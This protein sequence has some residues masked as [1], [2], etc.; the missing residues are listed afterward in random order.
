MINIQ[1]ADDPVQWDSLLSRISYRTIFHNWKWLKLTE[2]HTHTKLYPLIGFNGTT[3]VG[4]FPIFYQKKGFFKLVFSPPSGAGVLYLGPLII[5]YESMKQGKRES[6]LFEFLKAVDNFI[7]SKLH[8]NYVRI[9]SS[10]GLSDSRPFSWEGYEI[11]PFYTLMV[12][13]TKDPDALW[14][15]LDKEAR[16]QISKASKEGVSVEEGVLEDLDFLQSSLDRRLNEQGSSSNITK[17]YLHDLFESFFPQNLKIFIAKYKGEKIGGLIILS[18]GNRAYF[19][20]GGSKTNLKGIYPNDLVHWE[21]MKWAKQ[22]GL[23][24]YEVMDSG[25]SMRLSNYKSQFNPDLS[26]WFSATKYSPSVTQ[27]PAKLYHLAHKE[28]KSL[29]IL[30]SGDVQHGNNP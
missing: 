22:S 23:R 12:D 11:K 9:R 10:P 13:L 25:D 3:P 24:Y 26:A 20:V 29:N 14:G 5:D 21:T 7:S 16:R 6:T 17:P 28:I 18:Y 30:K 15:N 4:L 8:A 2:K 1:I 27:I 19:W